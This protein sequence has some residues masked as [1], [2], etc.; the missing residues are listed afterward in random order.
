MATDGQ[1]LG[2]IR[3]LLGVAV[4]PLD[5]SVKTVFG[6]AVEKVVAALRG[7]QD[8]LRKYPEPLKVLEGMVTAVHNNVQLGDGT[9]TSDDLL[10]WLHPFCGDAAL[11]VRPRIDVLQILES[12][13][14]LRDSDVRLLLL[15]RTQAVLKDREV[16]IEDVETEEKRLALFLELLE[17][18][19]RWDDFQLLV[20][21]L[22]AWP[23]MTTGDTSQSERN[24]WVALT[25]ALLTRCQGSEVTLD[26][27]RQVVAMVRSLYNTKHKLPAPCLRRIAGLM[28][29]SAAGLQQPALKLMSESGDE[30]LLRLTLDQIGSMTAETAESCDAELLSSLLDAGLL[31]G[32]VSSALYPPSQLPP[33]V[34]P[35]GGRLGRGERRCRA[36]G[37]RPRA[38]GGLPAAGSPR[39]PPGAV[40]LQLGTGCSEEVAVRRGVGRQGGG[41]GRWGGGG[42]SAAT[43]RRRRE[44]LS[45]IR[46][47]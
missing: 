38:R 14:S 10:S 17:A 32:C 13:F 34:P 23:P 2:H 5:L 22:Q 41:G 18:A 15:Y 47:D 12:N 4:G 39:D 8:S 16:Q 43:L 9:V 6:D 1:P 42:W 44:T 21:L 27:G 40:H 7:D 26:L 36:A 20:L 33:A 28:L 24:P 31:V 29:Q 25:S 45:R 30:E 46:L 19:R 3:D 11:P 35:A 37:G